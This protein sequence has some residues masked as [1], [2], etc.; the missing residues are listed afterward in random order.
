MPTTYTVSQEISTTSSKASGTITMDKSAVKVV[1]PQEIANRNALNETMGR[2]ITFSSRDNGNPVV[3]W[4]SSHSNPVIFYA[5]YSLKT[6]F[7]PLS[8]VTLRFLTHQIINNNL[9]TLWLI[10]KNLTQSIT[11]LIESKATAL[12][13]MAQAA[14]GSAD[15]ASEYDEDANNTEKSPVTSKASTIITMDKTKSQ[16]N[17]NLGTDYSTVVA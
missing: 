17:S 1:S 5:S 16:S 4:Q 11:T 7:K 13:T 10:A 9:F 6:F 15:M 14:T 8:F 3:F 2:P 12:I